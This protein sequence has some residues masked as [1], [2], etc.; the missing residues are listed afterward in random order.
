MYT[1]F[2]VFLHGITNIPKGIKKTT[3]SLL[4]A[5]RLNKNKIVSRCTGFFE[6]VQESVNRL[7]C[8][9]TANMSLVFSGYRKEETLRLCL[10][11]REGYFNSI[12]IIET[13]QKNR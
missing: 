8:L 10:Q 12:R 9:P 13:S 2:A 7:K 6:W 1:V 4:K 5:C 11:A 3:A